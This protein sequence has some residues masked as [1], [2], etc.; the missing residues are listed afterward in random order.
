VFGLPGDVIA[1]ILSSWVEIGALAKL[2]SALCDSKLRP[3]FLGLVGDESFVISAMY[4]CN[5]MSED[6]YVL[7][8]KWLVKRQVKVRN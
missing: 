2:D 3:L 8:F 7:H 6:E 5:N 1:A 4:T